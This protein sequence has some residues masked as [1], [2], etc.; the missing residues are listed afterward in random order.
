MKIRLALA[1]AALLVTTGCGGGDDD[2]GAANAAPA[3]NSGAG[4]FV[5]YTY[6]LDDNA[7]APAEPI[8]GATEGG[9]VLVHNSFDFTH[10]DPARV[11][12]NTE[13]IVSQ[14][15]TRTLTTY[16]V[17]GDQIDVIG[18]LATNTGVTKDGG[19][20]WT[21]TLREG[22]TWEDGSAITSADVKYG[23]ERTFVKDYPEGPTFVQSWLADDKDF[24]SFYAGPYGGK[25]LPN[26]QTPDAKTVVFKFK[27]A[28]PDLPF[29]LAMIA[30]SPVKKSEDTR[31]KYNKRPF[32][33]GPYKIEDRK[34]D[35]SM[36]LV[37]N[38]EWKPES[39]PI[40]HQYV[41]K[42]DFRFGE[43]A[44]AISQRL[45][46]AVGPDEASMTS[47]NGVSPEVL[48]QV[49]STPDLIGRTVDGY[50]PF[51]L[52]VA[53]NTK[54]ITD[55]RIRKALMYAYP[56]QQLRQI[57]GGPTNGDFSST[58]ASPTLIGFE[59]YDLFNVPPEGDPAKARALLEEA[60]A[61]GQQIVYAFGDTPRGQQ[62]S[63]AVVDALEEAGFTVVKK[64]LNPT[65][66]QEEI[67]DPE[68]QLDLYGG[69]WGADW[70][71][72]ATVYP[73]LFDGRE[74]R[75]G[76]YNTSFFNDP[77]IN[78]EMDEIALIAD[79]VEAGMRWAA[80]DRKIMEQVP[81]IPNLYDKNLQMYGPRLGGVFQ[82]L[83]FG[84]V[85]LNGV[86]VKP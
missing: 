69:G 31:L 56:R 8:P 58:L 83:V 23:I 36:T 70:P 12:S 6:G 10:L 55:L 77:A 17:T 47:L 64:A 30:T 2:G 38:P 41:D 57:L 84:T 19:K 20:T 40:R 61:V 53:I 22:V 26:V 68:N 24:R 21:Y 80:L 34:I 75:K 52:Y 71:S 1:M 13:Q 9:T 3:P 76:G 4:A 33:A 49:V 18:D 14:L 60:G 62:L 43:V 35:K 86:Y 48:Q 28:R 63:V 7:K 66:A 46:A 15:F 73:P 81:V 39:D 42:F 59:P 25:S 67:S 5:K 32:S 74:I 82:D 79:P 51:S 16:K 50:T 27:T 37:R 65:T 54:R 29:A 44:L 45:V 78:K 11:Y 85:S 72:G